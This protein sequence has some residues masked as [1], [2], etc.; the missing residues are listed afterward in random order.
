MISNP[1]TAPVQPS[2]SVAA[3]GELEGR[4][5]DKRLEERL[6][7]EPFARREP[8]ELVGRGLALAA[9]HGDGLLEG[10][11]AAVVEIGTG[12][13]EAPQRRCPPL[14]A[15]GTPRGPGLTGM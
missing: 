4:R 8:E 9:V 14:A 3:T 13:A 2:R 7:L 10:L 12:V 6:D 11:G 5:G 1:W 15:R